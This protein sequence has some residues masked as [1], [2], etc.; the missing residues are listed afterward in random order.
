V[1]D[2]ADGEREIADTRVE[3]QEDDRGVW[4]ERLE[5]PGDLEA[6]LTR[7]R[8]VEQDQ[9]RLELQRHAAGLY[10]VGGLANDEELIVRRE[11]RAKT[12]ADCEVVVGDENPGWHGDSLA[13]GLFRAIR[14]WCEFGR[15]D[16]SRFPTRST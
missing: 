7:H 14:P 1:G 6:S 5:L 2:R 13:A 10:A 4:Q 3:R 11:Q 8:V 16:V 15:R 12:L 9:V